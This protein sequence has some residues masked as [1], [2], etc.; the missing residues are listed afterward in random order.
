[1]TQESLAIAAGLSRKTIGRIESGDSASPETQLAVLSV[2]QD[3]DLKE[4]D[5]KAKLNSLSVL[6]AL[7]RLSRKTVKCYGLLFGVALALVVV[8]TPFLPG[9][10]E[11]STVNLLAAMRSLLRVS[12]LLAIWPFSFWLSFGGLTG[13]ETQMID[14]RFR[15][16]VKARWQPLW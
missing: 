9:V 4:V 7:G 15:D 13:P 5:R 14:S 1:M 6:V 11:S 10:E 8:A 16:M 3:I 2:L 12:V